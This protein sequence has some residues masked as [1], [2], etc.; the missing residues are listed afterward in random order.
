MGL[1]WFGILE[2]LAAFGLGTWIYLSAPASA[3]L[4]G[5]GLWAVAVLSLIMT[6]ALGRDRGSS[7]L[8]AAGTPD[9]AAAALEAEPPAAEAPALPPP[10]TVSAAPPLWPERL[11][12]LETELARS[13]WAWQAS[14]WALELDQLTHAGPPTEGPERARHRRRLTDAAILAEGFR[15]LAA[16]EAPAFSLDAVRDH[17][18][19]E[20]VRARLAELTDEEAALRDA[21]GTWLAQPDDPADARVQAALARHR[22]E[23]LADLE[24]RFE[25]VTLLTLGYRALGD[26]T[27]AL[28]VAS[29]E[30][31][32]AST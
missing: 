8:A 6:L 24:F 4:L 5:E 20:L 32:E 10:V 22:H 17:W 19:P 30:H 2:A 14:E 18:S 27:G 29:R 31:E 9:G 21:V 7:P 15:H 23:R 11:T 26:L 13:R 12:T 25:Q 3:T 28:A 16:G 1:F